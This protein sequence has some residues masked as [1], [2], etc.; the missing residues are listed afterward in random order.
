MLVLTVIQ[1]P[2][3]GRTFELPDNEP[4]LIGRS[5]ESLPLTDNTVSRRHAELTPDGG[6]W[7]I[8]DLGS[9]NGSFVNGLKI[10]GRLKLKPGDQIRTGVTLF[11]FGRTERKASTPVR[12]LGEDR[13]DSSIERS[14]MSS[15]DSV[16]LA[17]DADPRSATA[18]GMTVAGGAG[19][20]GGSLRVLYKLSSIV[21]SLPDRERL[22]A[23]VMDLIFAEFRPEHGCVMV[24][25]GDD[26]TEL[27]PAVVRFAQPAKADQQINVSRTILQHALSRGEGVLASNAMSDERFRKGDSVQRLSIRSAMCVPIRFGVP[28]RTF[29]AIYIDS[30]IGAGAYGPDQLALMNAI[31]QQTG[32]ALS[33]VDLLG[34]KLAT[35]RLAAIGETVASLSH[36]IKNIL[37]G[38]RGG[39]DVV[40]MGLRKED[41]KVA[42]GGWPILKRNLDRIISL[43]MN[44]L[45]Y[46][47]PRTLEIELTKIPTLL[48]DCASLMTDQCKV[49]G[50]ALIVDAESDIPPVAIDPGQIHQAV[51]NLLTNAVEAVEP[52]TGAVTVRAKFVP[53]EAGK[54]G[55]RGE[56]RI[57]VIDNGPGVTPELQRKIFEP[58]FT[59][60][61]L[62]GTGLGLAV[63]RRIIEGHGGK[64]VLSSTPS[65]GAT[66][67]IVLPF[68][69]SAVID[70]SATTD[71]RGR[72]H[73]PWK[74]ER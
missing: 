40:E 13:V 69:P 5:S 58:F 25:G 4:Q 21:S 63:T 29:G 64:L 6:E 16:I 22:L 23:G 15:E 68:D 47:R 62:R 53:V 18:A 73:G 36:S 71:T 60:K 11:T 17:L 19:G 45:A 56:L 28:A 67:G 31:G 24:Y 27:T 7:F 54:P 52:R 12:M 26:G 70:P 59:T 72:T 35:E 41:L 2:D 57:D 50:V 48:E 39:A 61:G 43:T 32:L 55:G 33:H 14:M 51:M 3:K 30:S 65:K 46:S 9:Q 66:F 10:E 49:R 37:Q 34:Q 44:M 74:L 20:A 42:R 1:G 38:L 8:R